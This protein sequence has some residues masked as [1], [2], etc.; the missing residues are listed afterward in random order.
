[1][2]IRYLTVFLALFSLLLAPTAVAQDAPEITFRSDNELGEFEQKGLFL[3]KLDVSIDIRAGLAQISLGATLRN[4]TEENAEA[5][6]AYPLPQGAVINGYAL[7]LDGELVDGVLM[8][9]ERASP[10]LYPKTACGFLSHP[11]KPLSRRV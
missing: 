8:S 5:T 2:L 9:K 10:R 3:E 6:F 11:P 4:D 7:D 1:M